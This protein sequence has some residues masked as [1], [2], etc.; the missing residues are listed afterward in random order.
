[1]AAI[2]RWHRL[3]GEKVWYLTG[4]DEN[5]QKNSQAAKL[6]SIP[7]KEFVDKNSKIFIELCRKLNISNDDFIRTANIIKLMI[8]NFIKSDLYI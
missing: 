5:A 6:A 3:N 2:A 7:T 4:T 1:M 8:I